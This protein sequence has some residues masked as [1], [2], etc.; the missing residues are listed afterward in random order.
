MAKPAIER[1]LISVSDKNGMLNSLRKLAAWSMMTLFRRHAK[2]LKE[3][4]VPVTAIDDYTGH[5]EIMDGP[6][7]AYSPGARRH[8][9]GARQCGS[10]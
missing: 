4:G 6:V 10:S 1:A 8:S 5:P 9:C 3:R 7:R 2:I